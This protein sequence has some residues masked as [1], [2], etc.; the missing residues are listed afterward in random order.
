VRKGRVDVWIREKSH[1]L[2]TN[3]FDQHN[4]VSTRT[5]IE[6]SHI[7]I[8]ICVSLILIIHKVDQNEDTVCSTVIYDSLNFVYG[9]YWSM[10]VVNTIVE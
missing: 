9:R 10:C 7:T 2:L 8:V 6:V 1:E 5:S 4:C 3:S